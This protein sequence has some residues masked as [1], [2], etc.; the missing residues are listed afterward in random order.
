M[1]RL[2]S[3]GSKGNGLV[4]AFRL[5]WAIVT[6]VLWLYYHHDV[7]WFRSSYAKQALDIIIRTSGLHEDSGRE[8][9]WMSLL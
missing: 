1:I 7:V 3:A 5:V 9:P 8:F 4:R 6:V 2:R